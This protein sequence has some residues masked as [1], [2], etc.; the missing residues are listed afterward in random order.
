MAETAHPARLPVWRTVRDAYALTLRHLGAL[1][2]IAWLWLLLTTAAIALLS[3]FL[4]PLQEL[5]LAADSTTRAHYAASI[6]SLVA[7]CSIAVAWHRLLLLDERTATPL[8]LRLDAVVSRYLLVALVMA[9]PFY[10]AIEVITSAAFGQVA[11]GETPAAS[12]GNTLLV[13]SVWLL[14]AA[15]VYLGVRLGPI[16]PAIALARADVTL[17]RV[18]RATRGHWWRLFAGL[19]LT[20]LLPVILVYLPF[21]IREIIYDFPEQASAADFVR[22]NLET[23]LCGLVGS[24]FAVSFL[25]LA[26]RHFFGAGT[27]AAGR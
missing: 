25:S 14:P 17:A 4:W 26:F 6:V 10:L 12:L 13:A 15:A 21:L 27:D 5:A 2:R 18:W 20:G 24:M 3:W 7:G 8:Y 19:V 1:L 23:E 9:V 22:S 16:L 11:E